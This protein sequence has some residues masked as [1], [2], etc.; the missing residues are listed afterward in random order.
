MNKCTREKIQPIKQHHVAD[1][2]VKRERNASQI[3]CKADNMT[4]DTTPTSTLATD[5]A[6]IILN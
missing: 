2:G 6:S 1:F 3:S 5:S 4:L